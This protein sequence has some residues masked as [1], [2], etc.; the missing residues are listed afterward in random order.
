MAE[1]KDL[2]FEGI[3]DSSKFETTKSVVKSGDKDITVARVTLSDKDAYL[4]AAKLNGFT[5]EQ[6][7][8]VEKFNNAFAVH[9]TETI[10]EMAENMMAKD[11]SLDRVVGVT[12]LTSSANG[13]L[14]V[15]IKRQQTFPGMNGHPAVTKSTVSVIAKIPAFELSK[16]N[17][18][19]PLEE[20]LTAKLLG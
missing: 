1:K 5:K 14:T 8:A 6:I 10:G 7:S 20:K 18:I 9:A 19:H 12:P 3:F 15:T 11:K 16:T 2:N 13:N 4:A 17:V